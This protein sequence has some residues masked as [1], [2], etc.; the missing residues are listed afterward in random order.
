MGE[1]IGFPIKNDDWSN[2]DAFAMALDLF[3]CLTL[4]HSPG[5]SP[6]APPWN[7]LV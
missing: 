1:V 3:A 2:A 5:G 6:L 4:K 7:L